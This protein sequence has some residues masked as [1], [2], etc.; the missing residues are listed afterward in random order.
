LLLGNKSWVDVFRSKRYHDCLAGIAVDEA[1]YIKKWY[2]TINVYSCTNNIL[3][4]AF[5]VP[6]ACVNFGVLITYNFYLC[7]GKEFRKEY[8]NLEE[9]REL[10]DTS[11]NLM[12]MTATATKPK[13]R[14]ICKLLGLV[15]P[16]M[17]IKSPEKP[18]IIYKVIKKI[19]GIEETLHPW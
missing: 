14:D 12:S 19:S 17:I 5:A 7:I 2:I 10:L 11:V 18:N 15:K 1:H 13:R 6:F 9:V 16:V 4:V 3:G 8:S